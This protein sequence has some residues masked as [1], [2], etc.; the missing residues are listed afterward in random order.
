MDPSAAQDKGGDV[1]SKNKEGET[2]LREASRE[3]RVAIV[4][5]LVVGYGH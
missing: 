1:N 4:Q 2:L 5:Y 3:G